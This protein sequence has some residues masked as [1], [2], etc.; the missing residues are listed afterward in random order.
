[1]R[2]IL[3]NEGFVVYDLVPCGLQDDLLDALGELQSDRP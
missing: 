3:R 2:A 1:M